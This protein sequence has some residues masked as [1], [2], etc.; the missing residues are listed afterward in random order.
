[1]TEF[2]QSPAVIEVRN[3][4]T[5]LEAF[6]TSYPVTTVAQYEAGAEDLKRVKAAQKKLEDTRTGITGP[7]NAALKKVNDFFRAPGELLARAE[8]T[9]KGSLGRYSEE[10]ERIRLEEQRKVDEAA[11]KER[12]RLEA[13]ARETERKARE[14]AEAERKAADEAA[15]AGRAEEAARLREKAQATEQKAAEKAATFD[16]RAATVVAPVIS[17]EPP[18][19][20]GLQMREVWE[21]TIV[22]ASKISPA[23]MMPDEKKIGAQVR[24]LKGDAAAIIGEGVKVTK[25]MAPASSAA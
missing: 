4:V 8:R 9:I 24:A 23:F 2:E 18:K 11:R 15:A 17:R 19:V 13:I 7:M 14:K 3:E 21:Y 10:Q 20:A 22:D 1:M 12:E 6:A 16:E 25:R 5:T